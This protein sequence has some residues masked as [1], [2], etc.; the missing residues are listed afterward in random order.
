MNFRSSRNTILV[1]E[2]VP[3]CSAII[4]HLIIV[5]CKKLSITKVV[6]VPDADQDILELLEGFRDV[7]LFNLG[8]E[9]STLVTCGKFF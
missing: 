9:V 1:S 3:C 2:F 6:K 7:Q 5:T 8:Q 4:Y